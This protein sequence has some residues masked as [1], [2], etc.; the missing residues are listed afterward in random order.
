MVDVGE[1]RSG[2]PANHDG[3]LEQSA[4]P[5]SGHRMGKTAGDQSYGHEE[6]V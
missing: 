5:D 4:A 3:H 2:V 6:P 1:T